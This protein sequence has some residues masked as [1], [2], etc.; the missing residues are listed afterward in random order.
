M[1]KQLFKSLI[2]LGI[3]MT[4]GFTQAQTVSGTVSD[5]DGPLPGAAVVVQGTDSGVTTD[6]DGNYSIEAN[7]GDVLEFSFVG[8]T[9]ATVTVGTDATIN[10]TLVASDNT[11]DE[12]VV[13]GYTTQTRGDLTGAV[14]SV[15]LDEAMKAPVV[16]AA[17]ALQG[18]VTGVTVINN[19]SPGG[20]PK[21]NIRGFG[22]S[23]NTNP[24]YIIDGVQ[25]DNSQTLNRINPNDIEQMNVLKDA[26][27][28]IYGARAANGVII[29]TT[30]SGGYNMGKAKVSF[31]FYTGFAQMINEPSLMNPEQHANM[32]WESLANDGSAFDHAQYGTG[33]SPVVPS[34]INGYKR[35]VSYD[36]IVFGPRTAAVKAGG[37]DWVGAITENA[38][39]TSASISLEN[40]S[41]TGKYFMSASYLTQDGVQLYTGFERI[42]TRLNSEFKVKDRI[43]IGEHLN[44][45]LTENSG[46]SGNAM[47]MALRMTPL[48]PT[49]DDEGDFAG[50]AGPDLSNTLNP[51]ANL[52]RAKDNYTK[53]FSAF[54]DVYVNVEIIDGLDFKSVFGYGINQLNGRYFSALTPEHGEPVS[55]NTLTEQDESSYNWTWTNT[56]QYNKTFGDHHINAMLGVEAYEE[57]WKGKSIRRTGYLFETP[58]FYLLENGSG[59]P[60]VNWAGEN[61][62]SLF[63][64]FGTANYSYKDKYFATATL[65]QDESSRFLGDNKTDIFPSFSVGWLLSKEGFYPDDALVNRIK[66]KASYGQLGNQTLPT[67]NP[68]INISV[69]SESLANYS[70][71]GSS[72][73]TGA[74]LNDVGNPDLKWETSVSSNFGLELGLWD[75]ALFVELDVYKITT[76][77]LITQDFNVIGPTAIDAGAPWVNLG[78]VENTG[79]DLTIGYHNETSF[80]LSYGVDLNFSQYK[81]EVTELISDFAV[82]NT[83]FRGGAVTRSEVGEPISSFYGRVV[84]GLDDTG[85]FVYKDV[86]NDGVI[87]DDDRDYI[88]SPHPD[89]TY[90]LNL[91]AGYKG[92]DISIFFTGSQGNDIYNY[93]KIYTHFPTFVNG[94]RSTDLL[95]SWTPSNTNTN[96]PA[97]S[98]SISNSESQPNSF[99]VEDGSFFRM[100]NLNIGYTFNKDISDKMRMDSFRIFVT[101]TNLFTVTDYSGIDPEL[102]PANNLTQGVDWQIYPVSQILTIGFNI[103]F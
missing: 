94:N 93:N 87:T 51:L 44:V 48:L 55:T 77:D 63:S 15:D 89:F 81:N 10:V 56:I 91:T 41:D 71:D 54:G 3:F 67:G 102:V 82:G 16:N 53:N 92:F 21:I 88:G 43:T 49:H 97:L 84:E 72:I 2:I 12:V 19:G 17:E 28:A 86:N 61:T 80:G 6:F 20:T 96:I 57:F 46:G 101:G 69:L 95:N 103:N 50:V 39:I 27:A 34:T 64:I 58:D 62:N 13:V 75:N 33:T 30:K 74:I 65:R 22:T 8:M 42:A 59:T 5:A 45:S 47:E 24:L 9:T 35:V 76:E 37:T 40:G 14:A 66:L 7:A 1:G 83:G 98:Q 23:N 73:T 60:V 100:K 90:G 85:R 18:R 52:S 79:F 4:C 26:S 78:S 38:P 36:P 29:I 70:F 11:L 99:F 25:T 68:T 31:D 32:L